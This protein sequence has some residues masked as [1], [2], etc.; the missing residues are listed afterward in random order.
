MRT[1]LVRTSTQERQ[2]QRNRDLKDDAMYD[3]DRHILRRGTTIDYHRQT[4]I[5]RGDSRQ[6]DRLIDPPGAG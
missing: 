1:F 2:E 5:H 3:G 6:R 4:H